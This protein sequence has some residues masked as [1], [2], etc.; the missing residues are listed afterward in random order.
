M[1]SSMLNT[2]DDADKGDRTTWYSLIGAYFFETGDI[3]LAMDGD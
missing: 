2:G 3:L 1:Q